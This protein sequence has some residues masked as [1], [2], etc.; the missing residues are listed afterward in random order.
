MP[1]KYARFVILSF[2]V[3]IE[4]S[5]VNIVGGIH[6]ENSGQ[7]TFKHLITDMNK[8]INHGN[9]MLKQ[10]AEAYEHLGSIN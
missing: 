5:E 9:L 7:G 6:R 1:G 8:R 2:V 4:S 10:D 3:V